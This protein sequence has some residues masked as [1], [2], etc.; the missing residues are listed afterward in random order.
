MVMYVLTV[1]W[2]IAFLGFLVYFFGYRIIL[3]EKTFVIRK[4]LIKKEYPY[5]DV[6]W[7]IVKNHVVFYY[8]GKIISAWL[9]YIDSIRYLTW[10]TTEDKR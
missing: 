3:K 4:I 1:L 6:T 2:G 5:K 10:E 8:K 9:V 7:K